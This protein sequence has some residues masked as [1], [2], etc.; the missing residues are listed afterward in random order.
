M[1]TG[2]CATISSSLCTRYP[3]D[4][5]LIMVCPPGRGIGRQAHKLKACGAGSRQGAPLPNQATARGSNPAPATTQNAA[6]PTGWR[7]LHV[8]VPKRFAPALH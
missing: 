3:P 5:G 8:H 6:N 1:P 7:R 2:P 4:R